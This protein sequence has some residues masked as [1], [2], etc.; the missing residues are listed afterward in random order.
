MTLIRLETR[1]L[2][3]RPHEEAVQKRAHDHRCRLSFCAL[4][5]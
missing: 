4:F 3:P 2:L 1:A 5:S